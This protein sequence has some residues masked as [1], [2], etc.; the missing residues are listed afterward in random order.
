MARRGEN[1]YKRKDG[2]YEGRYII[3]KTLDGK[4]RF[5]YVY[6][7]QYGEVRA[8][9]ACKKAQKVRRAGVKLCGHGQ[10]GEWVQHWLETQ[11]QYGVR[12][13]TY[14]C[15]QTIFRKHLLPTLGHLQLT[16]IVYEDIRHL[17][18]TMIQN[19]L[20][21][22]TRQSIMRF[23]R[24]SLKAAVDAGLIERNPCAGMRPERCKREQ[25]VLTRQEQRK[26]EQA[27]LGAE[28][29]STLLG[30]YLGLRVGEVSGLRWE[31][32]DWQERTLTVSRTVQR[33]VG[34]GFAVKT[35]VIIGSPKS[36]AAQRTLPI[37][38]FLFALLQAQYRK[39]DASGY[40]FGATHRG[41]EPRTLQ[42][43][44]ARL[45]SRTG[46]QRVHFHT[47]RHTFAT[48][49]LE[50]GIDLKTVSLLLGHSSPRITLEYYAHSTLEQQRGAIAR[51][52]AWAIE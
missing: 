30:L 46:L 4:T 5:G 19:A 31:D 39:A 44:F 22:S 2:R 26:I 52:G 9:L 12:P 16:Q 3:G 18:D 37:P 47:L 27:A 49:L 32:I 42:R 34:V 40:I 25:R 11:V 6:A 50:L 23:V 8:L 29:Y 17:A 51:L 1:I 14:A 20:S 10:Y 15:Y 38:E 28:D 36:L 13:S 24:S 21:P 33:S 45:L 41:I 35:Q 43:Q 48:R 7:R